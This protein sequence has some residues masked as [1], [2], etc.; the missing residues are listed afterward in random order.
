MR[1]PDYSD[2][3]PADQRCPECGEICAVVALDNSFDYAGTHCTY[4]RPGVHYPPDWGCPVSHCCEA[5]IKLPPRY[6]SVYAA[7]WRAA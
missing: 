2:M 3:F 6:E 1:L 7:D 5:P 4:G